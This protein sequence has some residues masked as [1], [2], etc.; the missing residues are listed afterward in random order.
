MRYL[1]GI[2]SALMIG[3]VYSTA[4]LIQK[5]IVRKTDTSAAL[6]GQLVR[7]PLWLLSVVGS[8]ILV[9]TFTLIGQLL[10][11]PTL[12][13]GLAAFGLILLPLGASR[14]LGEHNGRREYA[15]I[16][17][18]I[19]GVFF[20]ST[21][22]LSVDSRTLPW[23]ESSFTL[24]TIWYIGALT[25]LSLLLLLAGLLLR[26]ASGLR[27]ILYSISGG[28]C[29][30]ASNIIVFPISHRLTLL[31]GGLLDRAG[32]LFLIFS[33]LYLVAVNVYAITITQKAF[34]LADVSK[35]IPIQQVPI[36][37]IPIA[38]HFLLFG[39]SFTSPYQIFSVVI[40]LVCIL[41]GSAALGRES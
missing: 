40:A 10:I 22:S 18:I 14:F 33:G 4:S 12:I 36:Q 20:L 2:V 24:A 27:A 15:G 11:G 39:G 23:E 9:F 8:G 34:S 3:V 29:Y 26:K 5:S 17:S 16:A 21:S 35:L 1:L 19:I 41:F 7:K 31:S 30:A 25:A 6:I 37:L 13:P 38:T 32:W 28:I